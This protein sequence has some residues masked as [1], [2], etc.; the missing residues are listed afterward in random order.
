MGTIHLQVHYIANSGSTWGEHE[1]DYVYLI[2]ADVDLEPNPNEAS[3]G[4]FAHQKG[5]QSCLVV[6]SQNLS[7][8]MYHVHPWFQ[9]NEEW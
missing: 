8:A 6:C 2:Q 3:G 1:I 7:R 4:D 9:Q 5:Q